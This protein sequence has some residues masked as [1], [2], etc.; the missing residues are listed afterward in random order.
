[1]NAIYIEVSARV[2]YWEDATV[3]GTNDKQGAL[4]PLRNDSLWIPVIRLNDGQ[5][6][7]WP[8]GTKANIHYKVCDEG[9][10]WLQDEA[11]VRVAKRRGYYV[12]N[13]F[14]C[15]GNQ[16]YGDYIIFKV[17]KGGKI[18]GWQPPKVLANEWELM[19]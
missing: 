2:R 4:V 7:D 11:R 19:A 1:M 10:Y 14:L 12:P 8:A 17:G 3:N 15:H 13:D 18:V 9:E 16:G 5:I 6:M